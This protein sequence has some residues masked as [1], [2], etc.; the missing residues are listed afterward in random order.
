MPADGLITVQ[1]SFDPDE[2]TNRLEVAVK[3]KA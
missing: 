2:T 1:S 3:A